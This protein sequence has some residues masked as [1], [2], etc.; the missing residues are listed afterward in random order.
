[1]NAILLAGDQ[2]APHPLY[3]I[4]KAFLPLEGW[5]LFI[6]VLAALNQAPSVET[7]YIIGPRKQIMEEVE[8]ALFAFLF[9]KKIE[10]LEQKETL[11]ENIQYA[12]TYAFGMHGNTPFS[13]GFNAPPALFLPS[14]IPLVTG[15]EIE[16]FI[17]NSD[18]N[19]YD[20]CLGVTSAEH[21][22]PFYPRAKEPGIKMPYLYLKENA[23]RINNLHIARLCC[24]TAGSA[25]QT[26]YDHRHQKNIWNRIQ[27]CRT[28]FKANYA[29]DLLV[30]YILAQ[31]AS[32][33]S[34]LGLH[35]MALPFRQ[36]LLLNRVE[37]AAS[38]WLNMRFKAVETK[39]GGAALDI[40]DQA[41]YKTITAV[42]TKWHAAMMPKTPQQES[43]GHCPFENECHL[44]SGVI[45]ITAPAGHAAPAAG[46]PVVGRR[47][48][49]R[50]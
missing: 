1:M 48:I 47:D 43:N 17:A 31:V 19:Q 13:F 27:M 29:K 26:V 44:Q 35:R 46:V 49:D 4:N 28:L 37:E 33:L 36:P 22:K 11:L 32:L 5:P 10:V 30:F 24:S 50:V 2:K 34:R 3:D 15:Y 20:Y 42:F 41:T 16:S 6:H 9:T 38:A 39:I 18:T 40:D 8:K 45:Q 7:I 25:I 23:Y 21:L 14:D 12:Y